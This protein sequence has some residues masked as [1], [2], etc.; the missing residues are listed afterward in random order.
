M[1]HVAS[2]FFFLSCCFF[3][4]TCDQFLS[5]LKQQAG[6]LCTNV[7]LNRYLMSQPSTIRMC[8]SSHT[9]KEKSYFQ[10]EEKKKSITGYSN[11]MLDFLVEF[12]DVIYDVHLLVP[13]VSNDYVENYSLMSMSRP[14]THNHKYVHY[15][16]L[17][18]LVML[19]CNSP[20]V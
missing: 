14:L 20:N 10:K 9:I 7:F 13:I 11:I 19:N 17:S 1:Q 16:K 3:P 5:K 18:F 6:D 8:Q 2:L 4:F 12:V 15:H